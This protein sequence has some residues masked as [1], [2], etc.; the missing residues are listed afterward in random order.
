MLVARF[1]CVTLT[2]FGL[3]VDP[4]VNWRNATSSRPIFSGLSGS[5]ASRMPSMATTC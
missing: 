5:F 3:E 2:P 1:W 4:L